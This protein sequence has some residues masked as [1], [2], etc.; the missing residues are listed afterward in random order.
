[1]NKNKVDGT[2]KQIKGSVKEALGK[3]T[4]NTPLEVEGVAEKTAGK[5]QEG[6]GKTQ[7][8]AKDIADKATGKD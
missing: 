8:K 5:V 4:G 7:E 2:L 1:M 3:V 6:V